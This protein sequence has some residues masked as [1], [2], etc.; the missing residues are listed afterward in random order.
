[1]T[2]IGWLPL[3][4]LPLVLMA[5]VG[6]ASS[7]EDPALSHATPKMDTSA[8]P[9]PPADGPKLTALTAVTPILDSPSLSAKTI[10]YLRAGGKVSRSPLPV[11][12]DGCP[13]GW[14]AVR[15]RGF[16][17]AGELAS[18]NGA[19][20]PGQLAPPRLDMPLPYSYA[21]ASAPTR[22]FETAGN[23][24]REAAKLR[25]GSGVAVASA[26]DATVE[27]KPAHLSMMP[28]GR[29][30]L[31][32]DLKPA[33]VPTLKGIELTD[34]ARLPVAF[35]LKHGVRSWRIEKQ[36]A[37]K[38]ASLEP[39]SLIRL[40]GKF[41]KVNGENYWAMEDGKYVR[42][43][44]VTL[45]PRR[46][47]FPDFAAADQKWIDVAVVTGTLVAYE[48]KKAVYATLVSTGEDRFGDPKATNSTAL[49]TFQIIAKHVTAW[50]A[51]DKPFATDT[52]M[53]DVPWALELSSGLF[54]HGAYW[55]N[56]FGMESGPGHIH[57][58]P[59]DAAWIFRWAGPEL[60]EGWHGVS[61]PDADKK[62]LVVVHK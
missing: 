61:T 39:Q 47:I 52:D 4:T 2:R 33:E 62:T 42:H 53:V 25:K 20:P 17:C 37:E 16:V 41:R 44:D 24:L 8:V 43:K 5:Q 58:A 29:M 31:A 23:A 55:H 11:S 51:G 13:G 40:T 12:R 36:E 50:R 32:D 35:V 15:P 46:H 19:A 3:A 30:I 49:G 22:V 59:Q 10:G 60:P 21:R 18:A 57:L 27:G 48:G 7:H 34:Q 6:C 28:D 9:T 1:M 38:R 26:V 56:R 14:Y 54:L 45:V